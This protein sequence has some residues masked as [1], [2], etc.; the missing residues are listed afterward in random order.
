VTNSIDIDD[1]QGARRTLLELNYLLEDR[2]RERT[3]EVQ[4]L[5]ENAPCGYHSLDAAGTIVRINQT[6]LNWL[7]YTKEEMLGRPIADFATPASQE[8]LATKFPEFKQR[9]WLRDLQFEF[10]R[11]DGSILPALVN[12]TAIFDANGAYVMSRS[13]VFDNTQRKQAEDALRQ[14]EKTFQQ[15]FEAGPVARSIR[16][17]SDGVFIEANPS[18]L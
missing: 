9:G 16:R 2:V 11:K 1:L 7:G 13:S 8:M 14:S 3:A 18:F 6:E 15:A 17:M 5:Y 4:D 12:A 10:V